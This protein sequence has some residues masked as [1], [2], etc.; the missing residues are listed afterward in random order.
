MQLYFGRLRQEDDKFEAS[1]CHLV[2]VDLRMT[3]TKKE[4]CMWLEDTKYPMFFNQPMCTGGGGWGVRW[5]GIFLC[6]ALASEGD[7]V[8][9]EDC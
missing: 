7:R 1:L 5:G 9:L 8:H 4:L 3:K 6:L 2:R